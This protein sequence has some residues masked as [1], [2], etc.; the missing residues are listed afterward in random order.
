MNKIFK[1]IEYSS[2][3]LVLSFFLL[4]NIYIVILGIL[5]STLS[6]NKNRLFKSLTTDT[7]KKIDMDSIK[8]CD[9]ERS[10]SNIISISKVK[11]ELTLVES[12]EELGYIP[13]K[14]DFEEENVAS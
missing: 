12:I 5:L 2:I 1:F 3:S 6:I 8:D 11:S 14:K 9:S 4:H 7:S 10:E 13:S